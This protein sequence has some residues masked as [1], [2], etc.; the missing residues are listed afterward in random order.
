MNVENLR[1]WLFLVGYISFTALFS[2]IQTLKFKLKGRLTN[3]FF[4]DVNQMFGRSSQLT[5]EH[6]FVVCTVHNDLITTRSAVVESWE[7]SPNI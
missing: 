3:A 4:T 5:A 7:E 2:N 1:K 6:Y